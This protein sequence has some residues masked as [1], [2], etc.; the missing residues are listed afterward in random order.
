MYSS[1]VTSKILKQKPNS[2]LGVY[3]RTQGSLEFNS[4]FVV[5]NRNFNRQYAHLYAERLMKMRTRLTQAARSRWGDKFPHRH[6]HNLKSDE[7]C[8]VIGT[9]FKH[10]EFQPSIL[11]EVSEEHNLMPQPIKSRYTDAGDKLIM[12]DE[13]QRIILLGELTCQR[14]VTGVIVAV[15]GFEPE[16]KKGKFQVEDYCFQELP[17][18]IERPQLHCNKYVLFVS[19]LEFGSREQRCFQMQMLADVICGQLGA[20][21]QIEASADICH[22]IIAGNS[23]SESTQDRDSITKAKYLS[24][25]SSAGS[26]EAIKSLDDFLLQLVSS[27]DV[28]LIPGQ[29]DP[30]NYTLPQ[31]PLHPCMLPQ[32]AEYNT[33]HCQTNPCQLSVDNI[34]ILGTSGQPVEDILRYSEIGHSLEALEKTLEWGHLA[35][36]APDTLGCFPFVDEDPFILSECPHVYFA[37]C[38]P[39]FSQKIYN[40]AA[41]QEVLLLTIPRFCQ[42]GTAVLVNLKNLEAYPIS[43]YGHFPLSDVKSEN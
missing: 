28:T 13:L 16:D 23:L 20:D 2:S 8:I 9:L 25:K 43:F 1:T 39:E 12:E 35:P 5:K 30:S 32:A 6:L 27:V 24:K 3:N 36:T 31:Q 37:G 18:Q 17:V 11:K 29:F 4:T 14:N 22:V 7:R 10:M 21:D 15:M 34:R 19:G 42:T 38:Q 40:G 33:F 41:G 26:V